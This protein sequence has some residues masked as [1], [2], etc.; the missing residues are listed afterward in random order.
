MPDKDT[1][2]PTGA[3]KGEQATQTVEP[4]N[5]A[6]KKAPKPPQRPPKRL[7]PY[8]VVL[9][10]DD[11]HSYDYVIEMLGKVFGY[12]KEKAY[13][14]AR[15][16]DG[17]GRVIVLTTHKERAE[18]KRDQILAYG[19]DARISACRGSMTAIIEPAQG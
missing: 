6:P 17:S 10:D 5:V 18:L 11:D 7:P 16:V 2:G 1:A 13:L 14:L 15:E 4:P 9:L 8:N 12:A 3:D 19:R